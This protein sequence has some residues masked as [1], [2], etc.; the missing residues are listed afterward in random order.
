[1]A[2]KKDAASFDILNYSAFENIVRPRCFGYV[3]YLNETGHKAR[4]KANMGIVDMYVFLRSGF[5]QEDWD[6]HF[7]YKSVQDFRGA[8]GNMRSGA[9]EPFDYIINAF[10]EPDAFERVRAHLEMNLLPLLNASNKVAAINDLLALLNRDMTIQVDIY[11]RLIATYESGDTAAFFAQALIT[12]VIRS[13]LPDRERTPGLLDGKYEL[14]PRV[15]QVITEMKETYSSKSFLPTLKWLAGQLLNSKTLSLD[16][17]KQL[18]WNVV[19]FWKNTHEYIDLDS[20]DDDMKG[21]YE[22]IRKRSYIKEFHRYM[23]LMR[24]MAQD[25][26]YGYDIVGKLWVKYSETERGGWSIEYANDFLHPGS[27]EDDDK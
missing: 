19:A 17:D 20:L 22:Y 26:R 8:L 15:E 6:E 9:I 14:F 2:N 16:E 24:D 1:M 12:A 7:A 25:L 3:N 27:V 4:S 18:D 10:S 11:D 13:T 5:L 21:L 23:F